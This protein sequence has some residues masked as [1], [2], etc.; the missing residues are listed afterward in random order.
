MG[1]TQFYPN[2]VAVLAGPGSGASA[3]R[4]VRASGAFSSHWFGYLAGIAQLF[5]PKAE[6]WSGYLAGLTQL[7]VMLGERFGGA[8]GQ[9]QKPSA[10]SVP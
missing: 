3:P 4:G 6:R 10:P 8:V 1:M 9:S 5:V 2:R 7:F